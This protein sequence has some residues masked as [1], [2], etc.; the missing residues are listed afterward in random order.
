MATSPPT[1]LVVP[2]RGVG[3]KGVRTLRA[4]ARS[5]T[6]L[7]GAVI[8]ACLAFVAVF[9]SVLTPYDPAA[10]DIPN[11]LQGPSLDHLVGTDQL[12]R[13]ILS[14]LI[15]GTQIAFVVALPTMALAM[16][17]GLLL[18]VLAGYLGRRV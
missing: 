4:V 5:R 8:V 18:G 2:A 6:G 1:E 17:L 10:Q 11:R 16:G 15:Q 7:A 12:G 14:R 3:W 13:D 9:A